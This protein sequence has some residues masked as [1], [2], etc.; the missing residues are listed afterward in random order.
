MRSLIP[1]DVLINGAR[2][3][4]GVHGPADGPPVALIHGTPASALLWR[5]TAPALADSGYRVHL[6]DL[7]GFG[8]SERP[9][10]PAVDTSVSGQG[11]VLDR[12]LAHWG[13]ERVHLIGHDIGGAIALRHAVARP[14]SVASLTVM[15]PVSFDSWP[16]PR[17]RRQMRDGL[18][19]LLA[20]P[21]AEHRAHFQ[22]WLLSAVSDKAAF[23]RDALAPLL[24]FISGPIGQAS[25][26]QHQIRH[27]DARHT[28]DIAERLGGLADLP[29]QILWGAEDAWQAVDWARRLQAAIPGARLEILPEAGHFLMEDQPDRVIAHLIDHVRA[30]LDAP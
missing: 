7:L 3:A 5:K 20:K 26:F 15:D 25:L 19:S 13:L 14:E 8:W 9:W 30:H 6:Y 4:F 22:E 24:A 16:S 12:L 27:Y 17:T 28:L 2:I 21:D 18:E 10:D 29:V 23:E 1:N 11:P